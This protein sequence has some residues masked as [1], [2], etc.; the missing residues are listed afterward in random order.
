VLLGPGDVLTFQ[1]DTIHS[2]VNETDRV[3][4]SL[5]VYGMHVN[6][7][8]RSQFDTEMGTEKPFI[9]TID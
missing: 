3:S 7:A 5:H 1:P 2:V 9:L 6:H 4:I 8:Q